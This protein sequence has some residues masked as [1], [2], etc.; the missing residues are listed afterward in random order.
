MYYVPLKSLSS[1]K[2]KCALNYHNYD[3]GLS[4]TKS[5]DKTKINAS[6]RFSL[7]TI[8]SGHSWTNLQNNKKLHNK[9]GNGFD[10]YMQVIFMQR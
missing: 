9:R 6:Q 10:E 7:D 8:F 5:S 2:C 3:C 1:I 4:V